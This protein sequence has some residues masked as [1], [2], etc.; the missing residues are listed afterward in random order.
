[1]CRH[2]NRRG[3]TA[4]VLAGNFQ[5]AADI[6]DSFADGGQPETRGRFRMSA[7]GGEAIPLVDDL[8]R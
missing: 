8:K 2:L 5:G 7:G 6:G 1:M 3:G 4:I